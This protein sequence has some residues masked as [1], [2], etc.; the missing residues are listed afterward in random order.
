MRFW[1]RLLQFCL[2]V[3]SERL[4]PPTNS[5]PYLCTR[6][7]RLTQKSTQTHK[8]HGSRWLSAPNPDPPCWEA[9][10]LTAAQQLCPCHLRHIPQE[11]RWHM[12]WHSVKKPSLLSHSCLSR[13]AGEESSPVPKP[14][15][16]S[17]VL[18]LLFLHQLQV[19]FLADTQEAFVIFL[20]REKLLLTVTVIYF[21]PTV[22]KHGTG[23][24]YMI[25]M[26]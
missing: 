25:Y 6:W 10:V 1:N 15:D 12:R 4:L 5:L 13:P 16:A 8:L 11:T 19:V 18:S 14:G 23:L 26:S 21:K 3:C 24:D 9:T 17:S 20:L 2:I 7:R 22:L